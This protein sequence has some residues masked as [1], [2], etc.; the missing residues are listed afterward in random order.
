MNDS[1]INDQEES[2]NCN[3]TIETDDETSILE[4]L[5]NAMINYTQ[6]DSENLEAEYR[7]YI[8]QREPKSNNYD[9]VYIAG[10]NAY[11]SITAGSRFRK[12]MLMLFVI[13]F[14]IIF[15]FLFIGYLLSFVF[16]RAIPSAMTFIL[17]GLIGCITGAIRSFRGKLDE[18]ELQEIKNI[19][20][21]I[22]KKHKTSDPQIQKIQQKLKQHRK[23]Q[24]E[25]MDTFA[26]KKRRSQKFE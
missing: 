22:A 15:F 16:R 2:S 13:P 26:Q 23:K 9:D 7:Q 17:F 3:N 14:C 11:K 25:L 20:D 1:K 21:K 12:G 4:D 5:W 6:A 18:E 19:C 10:V 8:S 24:K